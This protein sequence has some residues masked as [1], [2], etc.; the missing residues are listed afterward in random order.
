MV[1]RLVSFWGGLFSEVILNF[2]AVVNLGIGMHVNKNNKNT[3][4]V[5][6]NNTKQPIAQ[7]GGVFVAKKYAIKGRISNTL[8]NSHS[9]E[10]GPVDD[11]FPTGSMY[12]I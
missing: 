5:W 3:Q 6:A 12:G 1:G 8:V 4:K 9:N 10:N 2:R 11:S 7:R